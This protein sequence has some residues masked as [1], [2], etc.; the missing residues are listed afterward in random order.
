MEA[1]KPFD[2][3]ILGSGIG[4]LSTGI[5]LSRLHWRVAVIE[6]NPL[7]GGLMRGYVRGGFDCP[8][9]VHYFGSYD[10][11]QPLRQMF[12]YLGV[13]EAVAAEK[14]GQRGPIDRYLFDDFAFD[15]PEGI[16]AFAAALE[17]AFPE[18]R[19]PIAAIIENIRA[20]ADLQN[21][22]ALFASTT[23]PFTDADLFLPLSL[24]LAKLNCS[25][26]LRSVLSVTSSWMGLSEH[27]CPVI[28]HHLAL[29]SYLSS[30]WRLRGCGSEL[31]EAFAARF[32]GVGGLLICHDPAVRILT[33]GGTVSGVR[34]ASGR[35]LAGARI[36]AAIHPKK[37]LSMLPEGSVAPRQARRIRDLAETEGLFSAYASLDARTQPEL[38]HNVYRLHTDPEGWISGGVFHQLRAG[39]SRATLLTMITKSPFSEWRRWENTTTGHRGEEYAA[40]KRRRAGLLLRQAGEIF[41]SLGGAQIIDAY[42][43]LTLRDWVDSPCGSPYGVMRSAQQLSIVSALH[44]KSRNGLFFAGQNAIA[45]GILGTVL[46]SFYAVRQMIGHDRFAAEILEELRNG[47]GKQG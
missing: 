2:A 14:M 28:Y 43:P 34:L 35:E 47:P 41:G 5:I 16:D 6:K 9:G 17:Q 11:G 7:P 15:L 46:G 25:P 13:T 37:V 39:G 4:G 12:D 26:R 19:R 24:Y 18:D 42:T 31:A 30:A 40:E 44:R 27:E 29:A 8:V 32:A 36:V 1:E 23:L 38:P 22:W 45:P 20:M 21:S 33:D 3:L 10:T